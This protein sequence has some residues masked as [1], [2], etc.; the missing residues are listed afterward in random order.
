MKQLKNAYPF[1]DSFKAMSE[2]RANPLLQKMNSIKSNSSEGIE[3]PLTTMSDNSSMDIEQNE[4]ELTNKISGPTNIPES[5]VSKV[6]NDQYLSLYKTKLSFDRSSI[7]KESSRLPFFNSDLLKFIEVN[8]PPL[9]KEY[10][11]S[12]ETCIRKDYILPYDLA[13]VRVNLS[14]NICIQPAMTDA[15]IALI[16]KFKELFG[17]YRPFIEDNR[18]IAVDFKNCGFSPYEKMNEI[19]YIASLLKTRPM[20]QIK[21]VLEELELNAID[22]IFSTADIP[23][24]SGESLPLK[25]VLP[26]VVTRQ[27]LDSPLTLAEKQL[28][29]FAEEDDGEI[30]DDDDDE[31]YEDSDD[32]MGSKRYI[33]S[34]AESFADPKLK[35]FKKRKRNQD[36][37]I[38]QQRNQ[39]DV[40]YYPCSHEGPCNADSDCSC[41]QNG[42]FCEKYCSCS[43]ECKNKFRG[44]D[45]KKGGCRTKSC[46]CYAAFRACDPDT[47]GV[48]TA[49]IHPD[50]LPKVIFQMKYCYLVNQPISA[51]IEKAELE[52]GENDTTLMNA[53]EEIFRTCTNTDFKVRRSKKIQVAQ[54]LIHGWGAFAAEPIKKNEFITEYLGELVSQEEA[55]R[56]GIVYDKLKLTYLFTLHHEQVIDATRKGNKAKYLNDDGQ[57]YNV[58]ARII[59][60]NG[61]H[62]VGL[63][64]YRNIE[65]GEELT[66]NYQITKSI[67]NMTDKNKR[68]VSKETPQ[69][70]KMK[71]D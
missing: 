49:Y 32:Q 35:K 21:L 1:L 68:K 62:R 28:I 67:T 63:F 57:N 33:N 50:I 13:N 11:S 61:D 70:K 69:T 10:L 53:E 24:D 66:F 25:S 23:I 51:L 15:E 9:T 7:T 34:K 41:Q 44:C 48:C 46:P 4:P 39:F 36:K 37:K 17:S 71:K 22:K 59:R 5:G 27:T 16:Y 12:L 56:R 30:E 20:S 65:P 38:Q 54:S 40:P 58:I 3:S 47:C 2:T 26:I 6:D 31:D 19:E 55:D 42:T 52:L 18:S 45:C 64:A 29:E 14:S 43:Y 8:E 60:V